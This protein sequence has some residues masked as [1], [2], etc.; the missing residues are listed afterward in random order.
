[1][2]A[3]TTCFSL[4]TAAA[5][6][7]YM[8]YSRAAAGL[9][10]VEEERL[11]QRRRRL[12]QAGGFVMCLLAVGLFAGFNTVDPFVQPQAFVMIWIGV[13]VLLM[14]VVLLAL[15]DLRLTWRLRH[16]PRRGFEVQTPTMKNLQ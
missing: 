12:R 15:M 2:S 10:G 1:M 13:F 7:Y 8:F 16:R 3:F 9:H 5:G 11:N 14:L 4:L 6:W